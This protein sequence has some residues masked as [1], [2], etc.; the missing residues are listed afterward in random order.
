[1]THQPEITGWLMRG[2]GWVLFGLLVPTVVGPLFLISVST[3]WVAERVA[4][5]YQWLFSRGKTI[6][7]LARYRAKHGP[8]DDP[9]T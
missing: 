8:T 9:A 7:A 2:L 1:M 6:I 5:P 3:R 4:Y